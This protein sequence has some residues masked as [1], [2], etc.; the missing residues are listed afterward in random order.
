MK[1]LDALVF[2]LPDILDA[3]EYSFAL[4]VPGTAGIE[5][6]RLVQP[7]CLL[8]VLLVMAEALWRQATQGAG[9]GLQLEEDKLSVLGCRVTGIFH[10]PASVAL[11]ALDTTLDRM[12]DDRGVITLE[13]MSAA[14]VASAA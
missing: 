14:L 3:R 8:P 4:D 1:T 7:D 11:L 6:W 13:A 2:A 12:A 10:V 9:F 5:P